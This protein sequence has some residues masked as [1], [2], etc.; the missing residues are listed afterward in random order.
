MCKV[1]PIL[2]TNHK[3][4]HYCRPFLKL[5]IKQQPLFLFESMQYDD[6]NADMKLEGLRAQTWRTIG[7]ALKASSDFEVQSG[8]CSGVKQTSVLYSRVFVLCLVSFNRVG[9]G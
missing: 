1:S 3:Y 8:V 5:I 6:D 4:F 9:T 2:A 7:M